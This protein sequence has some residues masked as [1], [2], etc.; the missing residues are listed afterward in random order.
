MASIKDTILKGFQTN[1]NGVNVFRNMN[2]MSNF[3]F[4]ISL[5]DLK[6][7]RVIDIC[8]LES[9]TH[10]EIERILERKQTKQTIL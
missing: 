6:P 10:S 4:R 8:K 2:V 3:V 9:L 1:Q 7:T 5:V